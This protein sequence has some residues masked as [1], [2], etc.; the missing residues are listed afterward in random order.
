MRNLVF[1]DPFICL[2]ENIALP[3]ASKNSFVAKSMSGLASNEIELNQVSIDLLK[4][5][6]WPICLKNPTLKNTNIRPIIKKAK[7][8]ST[9][10]NLNLCNFLSDVVVTPY[11]V[12]GGV[13]YESDGGG[14]YE[15]GKGDSYEG[16]G[17]DSYEE[18]GLP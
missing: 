5:P 4:F 18:G 3:I 1:F 6:A 13:P 11:W 16:V 9:G 7:R 14:S 8:T 2:C 10:R 15:V 17:G 12:A